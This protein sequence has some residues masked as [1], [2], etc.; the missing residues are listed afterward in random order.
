[1]CIVAR[2]DKFVELAPFSMLGTTS[3]FP[4]PDLVEDKF[5]GND[6]N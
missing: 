6:S 3:G 1:L 4:L 5:R 2:N